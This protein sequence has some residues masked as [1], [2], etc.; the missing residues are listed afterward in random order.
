MIAS[1]LIAHR[2]CSLL[3]PE[4]TLAALRFTAALGIEWVEIDANMLAD[5]TLVVFHDDVLDRLT[6]AQGA[7]SA[8]TWDDVSGL[9]VGSHFA[10]AYADE[11]MPRLEDALILCRDLGLGLNLEL[12]VYPHYTAER[13]AAASATLMQNH[14]QNSERLLVSSFSVEALRVLRRL[15]PDCHLGLLCEGVPENWHELAQELN[16]VSIHCHYLG[17]EPDVVQAV[18]DQGLDVYTYTV[19]DAAMGQSLWERGV[20]GLITDDP[21]LFEYS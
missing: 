1:P 8:A 20:N 12:K 11:R 21:L 5:D 9:D 18:R 15:Q 6:P 14:W 17:A 7:L 2:G 3:R 16:L 10:A 4:N 19:N 13:I